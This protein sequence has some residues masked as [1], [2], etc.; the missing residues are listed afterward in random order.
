MLSVVFS[1]AIANDTI[2]VRSVGERNIEFLWAEVPFA[3]GYNISVF[4]TSDNSRSVTIFQ[5]VTSSPSALRELTELVPGELYTIEVEIYLEN[6][7]SYILQTMT[8]T[9]P[10][11][12]STLGFHVGSETSIYISWNINS[13][14]VKSF[15]RLTYEPS[16]GTTPSPVDVIDTNLN[17]EGLIPGTSYTFEVRTVSGEGQYQRISRESLMTS[18]DTDNVESGE[19]LVEYCTNETIGITWG[20]ISGESSYLLEIVPDSGNNSQLIEYTGDRQYEFTGLTPGQLYNISVRGNITAVGSFVLQRTSPN[21]VSSLEIVNT[22][23]TS[24]TVRWTEP[25]V[26]RG[27]ELIF[28]AYYLSYTVNSGEPVEIDMIEKTTYDYVIEDVDPDTTVTVIVKTRMGINETLKYS[29][30]VMETGTTDAIANDTIFVR[31]VGERNIEILW[32]EVPFALG[33]NISVFPRSDNS[34]SLTIFQNVTSSPSALRELTELVP[35]ELYT[36]EVEIYLENGNS[37]ILQTMTRTYPEGPSTLGFHVGSETSIYI[38]WNI[39][40]NIVKSFFRL[41][42]EP[43]HGTTPSPVDVI[44]TNLNLEGLIPGTSYTFEVH[45]VSGEGQYQRISRESLMTSIDTKNSG[46][47]VRYYT[48]ETIGITWGEISGESSYLLEI[49]PDSGDNSQLIKYTGDRQYEFTGLTP[50]QLY[51][52]SVRGNITAVGSFI[53]QRTKPNRPAYIQ[54]NNTLDSY[55]SMYIEWGPPLPINDMSTVFNMYIL[56]YEAD[57][58]TSVRVNLNSTETDYVI[59]GLSHSRMYEISLVTESYGISSDPVTSIGDTEYLA[60]NEIVIVSYNTENITA[61]WGGNASQAGVENYTVSIDPPNGGSHIIDSYFKTVTFVDLVPGRLYTI[62]VDTMVIGVSEMGMIKQRTVPSEVSVNAS[63]VTIGS[64]SIDLVWLPPEGDFSSFEILHSPVDGRTSALIDRSANIFSHNYEYFLPSTNY[65]F[66]IVTISSNGG[67]KERSTPIQVT[68]QTGEVAVAEIIVRNFTS[69]YLQFTWGAAIEPFISYIVTIDPAPNNG[70]DASFEVQSADPKLGEFLYLTPGQLYTIN[71]LVHDTGTNVS[72]IFRTDPW[73]VGSFDTENNLANYTSVTVNWTAPNL[74]YGVANVFD[75]Y[76][77]VYHTATSIPVTTIVDKEFT[78]LTVTNLDPDKTY[79]FSIAVVSGD[80]SSTLMET[81]ANTTSPGPGILFVRSVMNFTIDVSWGGAEDHPDFESY[82]IMIEPNDGRINLNYA[83]RRAI[84]S[85]LSAGEEYTISLD[86]PNVNL[87]P[88][89]YSTRFEPAPATTLA[90]TTTTKTAFTITWNTP[91]GVISGYGLE[92]NG[93]N[94]Q[95]SQIIS[96]ESSATTY[97]ENNLIPGRTYEVRLISNSG[98]LYSEAVLA[99]ATLVPLDPLS[100]ELL[101]MTTT[102]LSYHFGFD[103]NATDYQVLTDDPNVPY[104]N[105]QAGSET[106]TFEDLTPG[107]LYVITIKARM[108]ITVLNTNSFEART[109]PLPVALIMIQN[110]GLHTSVLAE[111][112]LPE[113]SDYTGFEVSYTDNTNARTELGTITETELTIRELSP[114]TMYTL[115]VIV[116]SGTDLNVV[117][118]S[119]SVIESFTTDMLNPGEVEVKSFT[120]NSIT[121]VWGSTDD[122]SATSYVVNAAINNVVAQEVTVNIG[123]TTEAMLTGLDSGLCYDIALTITGTSIET[124]I[125]ACTQPNSVT[126]FESIAITSTTVDLQWIAPEGNVDR[127]LIT[128]KVTGSPETMELQVNF[129][130]STQTFSLLTAETIYDITIVSQVLFNDV[131]IDSEPASIQETTIASLINVVSFTNTSL[132]Y[133][134]EPSEG[135]TNNYQLV[136]TPNDGNPA[137]PFSFPGTVSSGQNILT[138]LTPGTLYSLSWQTDGSGEFNQEDAA[139]VYTTPD[140]VTNL[141]ITATT[142]SS[143]AIE[144]SP[145]A[146]GDFDGY[147]LSYFALDQPADADLLGITPSPTTFAKTVQFPVILQGLG[148]G[149]QYFVQVNTYAGSDSLRVLSRT[150][151]VFMYTDVVNGFA[152]YVSSFSESSTEIVWNNISATEYTI[153]ATNVASGLTETV[154]VVDML[155]YEFDNLRPGFLYSFEVLASPSSMVF[156]VE[157][158]TVPLTPTSITSSSTTSSITVGWETP[159]DGAYAGFIVTYTPNTGNPVSPITVDATDTLEVEIS[160]LDSDTNY[161]VNIQTYVGDGDSRVLAE[162]VTES[163]LTKLP[164]GAILTID[165]TTSTTIDIRWT[166][167]FEPDVTSFTVRLILENGTVAAETALQSS[168]LT[169][170]FTDLLPATYYRV[171]VGA[172]GSNEES[173]QPTITNPSAVTDLTEAD[174]SQSQIALSWSTP[175]GSFDGYDV[176]YTTASGPAVT[177]QLPSS[178]NTLSLQDLISN[179]EYTFTFKTYV[180]ISGFLK[181]SEETSI[182]VTTDELVLTVTELSATSL[183]VTWT[184]IPD[185]QYELLI[186]PAVDGVN[187]VLLTTETKDFTGLTVGTTY[188]FILNTVAADQTRVLI[189]KTTYTLPPESPNINNILIVSPTSAT[190]EITAPEMGTLDNFQVQ[191]SESA[192]G[193]GAGTPI[194]EIIVLAN[195]GCP[196]LD[197]TGLRP[198]TMYTIT[199]QSAS[200]NAMSDPVS[201]TFTTADAVEGTLSIGTVTTDSIVVYWQKLSS[202]TSGSYRVD[203]YNSDNTEVDAVVI[204]YDAES[205]YIFTQLTEGTQYEINLSD[206]DS[207]MILD[208]EFQRTRPNSPGDV[209]FGMES[210]CAE[211]DLTINWSPASGNFDGYEICYRPADGP[212]SPIEVSASSS[213]YTLENLNPDT[214]YTISVA[215]YTGTQ[216]R[217]LSDKKTLIIRTKLDCSIAE[218]IGLSAVS[219]NPASIQVSW[220]D[221]TNDNYDGFIVSYTAGNGQPSSSVFVLKDIRNVELSGLISSEE[222]TITLVTAREGTTTEKSGELTV[223]ETTESMNFGLVLVKAGDTSLSFTWSPDNTPASVDDYTLRYSPQV[224]QSTFESTTRSFQ[225]TGLQEDTDYTIT[226]DAKYNG[227]IVASSP[228]SGSTLL[229]TP[230]NPTYTSIDYGYGILRLENPTYIYDHLEVSLYLIVDGAKSYQPISEYNLPRSA[231]PNLNLRLMQPFLNYVIDVVAVLEDGS[232]SNTKSFSFSTVSA[233]SLAISTSVIT[234]DSIEFTWTPATGDFTNYLVQYNPADGTTPEITLKA[235]DDRRMVLQGLAVGSTYTILVST[236]GNDVLTSDEYTQ[237]TELPIVTNVVAEAVQNRTLNVKWDDNT[238]EIFQICYQTLGYESNEVYTLFGQTQATLLNLNTDSEYLISVSTAGGNIFSQPVSVTEM[239]QE[240]FPCDIKSR[241]FTTDSVTITWA[242]DP[243]LVS[244]YQVERTNADGSNLFTDTV[245]KSGNEEDTYTFTN[246]TPG[247]DYDFK[248]A[249]EAQSRYTSARTAPLPPTSFEVVSSDESSV[250]LAWVAPANTFVSYYVI[251]YTPSGGN[252]ET[253]IEVRGQ[254]TQVIESLTKATRYTFTIVA[255]A[256]EGIRQTVSDSVEVSAVTPIE[257]S[258]DSWTTTVISV[259]WDT[260]DDVFDNYEISYSP[261]VEMDG[262]LPSPRPVGTSTSLEIY[263]LVPGEEYTITL[264]TIK[265]SQEIAGLTTMVTQ[266]TKP[267]PVPSITITDFTNDTATI[268]WESANGILDEYEFSFSS[269]GNAAVTN[270]IAS[271]ETRSVMLT[272]LDTA[273]V[274]SVT[275]VTISSN[276]QSVAVSKDFSTEPL[277]PTIVAVNPTEDSISLE[278]TLDAA[279]DQVYLNIVP[280]GGNLPITLMSTLTSYSIGILNSGRT[281]TISLQ[282]IA[283]NSVGEIYSDSISVSVQTDPKAPYDIVLQKQDFNSLQFTWSTDPQD[284]SEDYRI[285]LERVSDG[286]TVVGTTSQQT[287]VYDGL[288]SATGYVFSVSTNSGVKESATRSLNANTNVVPPVVFVD[289]VTTTSIDYSWGIPSD[290][291]YD[292]ATFLFSISDTSGNVLRSINQEEKTYLLEGLT[293]FTEYIF[294][295]VVQVMGGFES[296]TVS[297]VVTTAPDV[298]GGVSALIVAEKTS[299]DVTLQWSFTGLVHGEFRNITISYSSNSQTDENRIAITSQLTNYDETI[300]SLTPGL[301][302]TFEVQVYNHMYSSVVST[303]T[304]VLIQSAPPKPTA[305]LTVNTELDRT[306]TSLTIEMSSDMFSTENGQISHIVIFV[307]EDGAEETVA[308]KPL[309][310]FQ[311]QDLDPRPPYQTSG[312]LTVQLQSISRRRRRATAVNTFM[313]GAEDCNAAN[314]PV[315]CNGELEARN[316]YRFSARAYGLDG[317]YTDS[318]WSEPSTTRSDLLWFVWCAIAIGILLIFVLVIMCSMFT[319]ACCGERSLEDKLENEAR[320]DMFATPIETVRMASTPSTSR[321]RSYNRPDTQRAPKPDRPA[322]TRSSRPVYINQ[323]ESHVNLMLSESQFR[324][325]DEYDLLRDVCINEATDIGRLDCNVSKNRYRNILPFDRSSVRLSHNGQTGSEYI[326]AN[327]LDGYKTTKEYIVTQ[328]PLPD[329]KEDF[330]RMI[331]EEEVPTIVMV[332]QCVEKGRVKCD[333]YWPFDTDPEEYG[334]IIVTMVNE[335]EMTDYIVRDFNIEHSQMSELRQVKQFQFTSWMDHGVPETPEPMV[336]FIANIRGQHPASEGPMVVHCSAGVGRSGTFVACDILLQHVTD[337]RNDVIDVFG[338]VYRMRTQRCYMV[339]TEAQYVFIHRA[340]L[341]VLKGSVSNSNWVLMHPGTSRPDSSYR[342]EPDMADP[343]GDEI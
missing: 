52:I 109:V 203:I 163:V 65:T 176:E 185:A 228:L 161:D 117:T 196:T 7:D 235:K 136:Y 26:A 310:Y 57:S 194:D 295:I 237:N 115:S 271:D 147:Q 210:G 238:F 5:N 129:G 13:N 257:L 332:T 183:R 34:R 251:S 15:F 36:I 187:S 78:S 103:E 207:S 214:E 337:Q 138:D 132:T 215:A 300:S 234:A 12:P 286:V 309:T 49:V 149:V 16:H 145:P 208:S 127:Y 181:E 184:N 139:F 6:R 296:E 182:S 239:T 4:P 63:L 315:Y 318:D 193:A 50:G 153:T 155:N 319:G 56:S 324:F 41:T 39:N 106:F 144:W 230:P 266:Q 336:R 87:M 170:Q 229:S 192:M 342:P 206:E 123:E 256:G 90:V 280:S 320:N 122:N 171:Y 162:A 20:E 131:A 333:H 33:Y 3:L 28:G 201:N 179:T 101:S 279:V 290:P 258:I 284:I 281:Y 268:T 232:R 177:L 264:K 148:N 331:W 146:E 110:I 219:Q 275:I 91:V 157:Q 304:A 267:V 22:T 321:A 70:L 38:S 113:N 97:T 326:N 263:G 75:Y 94:M 158:I 105:I 209:T 189:A 76:E 102:S 217:K 178:D 328:G 227:N 282:S 244:D 273:T 37:Y 180:E 152:G 60:L 277:A 51:N 135:N 250:S 259:T 285:S 173:E 61:I 48:N 200:G 240:S 31:S 305:V 98:A 14:I 225:L 71:I 77:I 205:E 114:N 269:G 222:Y 313:V 134:Y 261:Y 316:T 111:W 287:S 198:S 197:I 226:L 211:I 213:S 8:R 128:Y 216:G 108:I 283:V 186:E 188:Q 142:S 21:P 174:K 121:I 223:T 243:E 298:P 96:L 307:T 252:P 236:Q 119:T 133:M 120:S 168:Q 204:A 311:V 47:L 254:L 293:P 46:V 253:P 95:F 233:G 44:D 334:D 270:T 160:D 164:V 10:E 93:Y 306:S 107:R 73:P 9:Y 221:P 190:V 81:I 172:I 53:L 100:V 292:R 330:W 276:Q 89:T 274:Y 156:T 262:S 82:S 42:Y 265:D 35:G 242:A 55:T 85:E 154:T 140:V 166:E 58:G 329:S 302:Y 322:W 17:L 27:L 314:V 126:S 1:D 294:N 167:S 74:F 308:S 59:T 220:N 54:F 68:F 212:Q 175:T 64:T 246:L 291:Q 299:N 335:S 248:V 340:I 72:N 241:T 218:P 312:N 255:Y 199:V 339:Q 66:E 125:E 112:S 25:E 92:I 278:W 289:D 99:E 327:Y 323:Y 249:C 80:K 137:S 343:F 116:I 297:H 325:S 69:T 67:Y 86:V 23:L 341:E 224:G 195:D 83:E 84:F 141:R 40:S 272:D 143:L 260:V 231:C 19:I 30:G 32:A 43:S 79:Y 165:S 45:T 62:K 301:T 151:Q 18:I 202:K 88:D 191:V 169:Y 124:N 104:Q 303:V 130:L 29:T 150:E 2:F 245:S 118:R 24:L 288:L 159:L 317:T 247:Q 338:V 11:G